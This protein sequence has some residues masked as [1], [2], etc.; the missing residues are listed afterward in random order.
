MACDT[1]VVASAASSVPEVVGD[2]GLLVDPLDVSA[3]TK[4]LAQALTDEELRM[5]LT[6]RGHARVRAFTW[7]NAAQQW[8]TAVEKRVNGPL[9]P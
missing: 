5:T 3:W 6:R 7:R 4:A 8:L 9:H 1:P 2:A